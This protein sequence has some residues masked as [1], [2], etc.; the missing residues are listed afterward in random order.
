MKSSKKSVANKKP[1]RTKKPSEPSASKDTCF[2]IM[3]FG[4]WFDYYYEAIYVPAIK[5]TGLIPRRADDLYRPS[6]IVN[7]IWTLTQESK[8]ILAD[9]SGKNPNVFYELGLAHALTKP[10]ILVTESIDDVPFDLRS[11]RVIVY[12]KNEPNWGDVLS[13]KIETAIKEIL[14]APLDAVLPTFLKVNE[15][16]TKKTVSREEKELISM[17][18]DIDLIKHQLQTVSSP[19]ARTQRTVRRTPSYREALRIAESY[20]ATDVLMDEDII[21]VLIAEGVPSKID[22]QMVLEDAKRT[23]NVKESRTPQDS[24]PDEQSGNS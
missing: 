12:D 19:S 22:A 8:V 4:S 13:Q 5:S 14:A 7:D 20:L 16:A 17:K 10:A 1:R 15:S 21:K 6:A 23:M 24:S 3:P 9:L 18:Q 2:T 11:L